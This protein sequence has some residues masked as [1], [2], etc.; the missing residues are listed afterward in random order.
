MEHILI[1]KTHCLGLFLFFAL[2]YCFALYRCYLARVEL[3]LQ[4]RYVEEGLLG[5]R[6]N[7]SVILMAIAKLPSAELLVLSIIA[8]HFLL[9]VS[10]VSINSTVDYSHR[11]LCWE[12]LCRTCLIWSSHD[13][14]P[15]WVGDYPCFTDKKLRCK[16]VKWLAKGT[17]LRSDPRLPGSASNAAYLSPRPCL[18]VMGLC[19]L[20]QISPGWRSWMLLT[21]WQPPCFP[22]TLGSPGN[23]GWPGISVLCLIK[24]FK[25][26]G[27]A[28]LGDLGRLRAGKTKDQGLV[29]QFWSQVD[30]RGLHWP[31][32]NKPISLTEAKWLQ[33]SPFSWPQVGYHC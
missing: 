21:Q 7:A 5:Q 27:R 13:N 28:F 19:H 4:N 9:I 11:S 24:R 17:E 6:I 33:L 15:I 32:Q 26:W 31:F 29:P 18:V 22:H 16:E 14:T 30:Q 12:H 23:L 20:H 8:Q 1:Y 3:E 25:L 2:T 10:L